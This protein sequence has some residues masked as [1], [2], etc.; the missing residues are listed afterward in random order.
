MN[1]FEA[2]FEEVN[3]ASFD[4]WAAVYDRED[5]PLL[6][7]EERFL[8]HMLPDPTGRSILDIGCGTGRWLKHFARLGTPTCMIGLDASIQMLDVAK[9]R[10]LA[11]TSLLQ[12]KL[13]EIPVSSASV[14]LVLAS[15]VLSY[16]V[17]IDSCACEL[18]RILRNGDDVFITDMHPDTATQLG[19]QRRFRTADN[20]YILKAQQR[21]LE[22]MIEAMTV[23]GFSLKVAYEPCFGEPEQATF[24][25]N[26][27]NDAW[28]AAKGKPAIYLLHFKKVLQSRGKR[29]SLFIE[30]AEGAI[31][32]DEIVRANIVIY[33]DQIEQV[34]SPGL[35]RKYSSDA[36]INLDGYVLFPGLI[37]A[38]D[39]LEFAL[40]P[41]LGAPPYR[42]A[43]EWALDIQGRYTSTIAQHK[44][45]PKEVRLWW[46]GIRNLLCGVTT[47]CHHNPIGPVLCSSA[48][49]VKVVKE[50]DWE[51]SPAFAQDLSSSLRERSEGKP[52]LIHA[53]EGTDFVAAS[54]L[55]VL[56]Q[57]GG[58]D[59]RTV[60]VHGL[61]LNLDDIHYLNRHGAS[62]VACI[63][64]NHFLFSQ[65]PSR[66]H[67]EAVERLALGSDSPLTSIGDLLDEI[68]FSKE[69]L[70]LPASLLYEAVTQRAARMLCLMQGEGRL[71][72]GGP[73][74]MFAVRADRVSPSELLTSLHWYD[75]ELVV[76]GGAIRLASSEM[77]TLLPKS[78]VHGLNPIRID[79]I[80]RWLAAPTVRLFEAAANVLGNNNVSLSGRN[81]SVM[82]A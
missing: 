56:K 6:Q 8:R 59:H 24:H 18:S 44:L 68:R 67:L 22:E 65:T 81:I 57:V 35:N 73:S 52:F 61:A 80:V 75:V 77:L 13:P 2:E 32:S 29:S 20:N 49:P 74:D 5:N 34:T 43:T 30:N 9:R 51:H 53:C 37:N 71:C 10:G 27:M 66:E 40:F 72:P 21:T 12:A 33:E 14:D 62:L 19:W 4:A 17:D 63:S 60:L 64:S 39:H 41:R 50:F 45:V 69:V 3:A 76:V 79:G 70:G 25:R 42:N 78:V 46:G 15:F 1:T 36:R 54:D 23:A 47:V 38:H 48:F 7:L 82:E 31:G 26:Q 58:I 28:Q 16:I 55:Q 11:N